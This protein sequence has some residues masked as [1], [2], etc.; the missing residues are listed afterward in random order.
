[1]SGTT[2][3]VRGD[4]IPI[5]MMIILASLVFAT[6]RQGG[7]YLWQHQVFVALFGLGVVAL[8]RCL[9]LEGVKTVAAIVLPLV[10]S[11][12]VSTALADDRSNAMST[13]VLVG[14]VG[15]A[16]LAGRVVGA[17]HH[18]TTTIPA[19]VGIA[20]IVAGSAI[21]GV[22]F[23]TAP[24]GR[25]TEGVW[26]GSSVLTYANASAG[27][28]GPVTLLA[29]TKAANQDSRLYAAAGTF[30]AI[31]LVSTQSRGGALAFVLAGVLVLVH[32]RPRQFAA[33]TIPMLVGISIG[34]PMLVMRARDAVE[35]A[36]PLAIVLALAGVGATV[37]CW[38][39][40]SRLPKPHVLLFAGAPIGAIAVSLSGL[41]GSISP[42]LTLRSG[43]TSGGEDANVLLGDRAK[44]W[45]VA[46]GQFSERP[47]F[48]HGPGEVE[49]RW[50]EQG[51]GF[52]AMFVH[53]EYLEFGVTHGVVGLAALVV[54]VGMF[55]H[56]ARLSKT[57][58]PL[59]IALVNFLVHSAFD[60][61]WHIP[62]LPVFFASVAG[63]AVGLSAHLSPATSRYSIKTSTP[64]NVPPIGPVPERDRIA[65]N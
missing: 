40:R 49:L 1:M 50:V 39:H 43:T 5:G 3:R 20:F 61:L 31:G 12:V 30:T 41:A 13:F 45:E 28:L 57:T 2:E 51:R 38:P 53:N 14:L 4:R 10:L 11:S 6:L 35:P 15:L 17:R 34:A 63:V 33:T 26:R 62:M 59:F 47:L 64:G 22:S 24:W 27:V 52:R 9:S 25:I 18:E 8:A 21:W 54:S 16:M 58:I 7:Y 23:Q 36:G 37:L 32:L 46:W 29:M 56:F 65:V 42:R 60:F 19:L 44:T 48:G 55:I